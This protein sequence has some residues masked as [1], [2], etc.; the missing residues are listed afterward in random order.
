MKRR[1]VYILIL[2]LFGSLLWTAPL[3]AAGGDEPLRLISVSGEAEIR[4]VP[5]EVSIS[6]GIETH[7]SNLRKAKANNDEVIKDVIAI[8][9]SYGIDA[10]HIQTDYIYIDQWYRDEEY[11]VRNTVTI[12]LRDI[13]K[14]ENLLTSL[15]DAGITEV[16]GIDF[17]TTKLREYRDEARA[18]AIQAA[19]EKAT[20]LADALDQDIGLPHSIREDQ[21]NTWSGYHYWWGFG[22]SGGAMTQN[23][24]QDFGGGSSQLT[25]DT[26]A[27]GQISIKANVSVSFAMESREASVKSR[28]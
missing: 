20:D 4:V 8:A 19:K 10:R 26:V 2:V 28:D 15:V 23:V 3:Y 6:V 17:R 5:D 14:F 7:N 24:I 13:A 16:H 22:R 1:S 25:G 12:I 9:K 18:L 21:I 11:T 27:P